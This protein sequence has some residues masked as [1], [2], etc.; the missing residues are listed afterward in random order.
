M[1]QKIA[2]YRFASFVAVLTALLLCS[3]FILFSRY[4]YQDGLA[5][6]REDKLTEARASFQSALSLLPVKTITHL[7]LSDQQKIERELG[8]VHYQLSEKVDNPPALVDEL[9]KSSYHFQRA[10]ALLP[11]DYSAAAGMAITTASQHRVYQQLYPGKENLYDASSFFERAL[12]LRPNGISLRFEFI[13]Y[14]KAVGAENALKTEATKLALLYPQSYFK[15]RQLSYYEA[16][17]NDAVKQ[18]LEEAIKQGNNLRDAYSAFS[19]LLLHEGSL[20]NSLTAYQEMLAVWPDKNR[21]NDYLHYGRLLLQAGKIEAAGIQF[22]QALF[23]TKDRDSAV[24]SIFHAYQKQK[25]YAAF[26][27]ITDKLSQEAVGSSSLIDIYAAKSLAL[28]GQP[29]LAIAKLTRIDDEK[30]NAEKFYSLA[31]IYQHQ[32]DWDNMELSIQR[33]T[34]LSPENDRYFSLFALSLSKQGKYLQAEAAMDDTIAK[35]DKPNRWYYNQRG[36]VRWNQKNYKGA[37]DD[38]LESI[39]LES[40]RADFYHYASIAYQKLGDLKQA[41][42]YAEEAIKRSPENENYLNHLQQ[43]Q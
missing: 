43:L 2:H 39:K 16:D 29:E 27:N 11:L 4:K 20:T 15:L 40:E 7:F 14:L 26:V 25:E 1:R 21:D 5:L 12:A 37:L 28:A 32:E 33:A 34:L 8:Q 42:K 18:G 22:E 6:L 13:N 36:W 23:L 24:R 38:W 41:E 31:Q 9:R 30:Y 35:S 19:T 17:L 3:F 10:T